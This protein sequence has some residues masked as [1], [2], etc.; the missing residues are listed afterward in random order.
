MGRRRGGGAR[1]RAG[2]SSPRSV[3]NLRSGSCLLWFKI[4]PSRQ[5]IRSALYGKK[6]PSTRIKS[7]CNLQ[8]DRF[9]SR[10]DPKRD[11]N[12]PRLCGGEVKTAEVPFTPAPTLPPVL[13]RVPA[14]FL[15][16][17]HPRALPLPNI[18]S[19]GWRC[20]DSSRLVSQKSGCGWLSG[21]GV[22]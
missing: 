6:R 22:P 19:G 3:V 14:T 11:H 20:V 13:I 10:N 12:L 18:S 4:E 1:S 21:M 17:L 5:A 15:H 9:D 8:A 16:N 2:S 7:V